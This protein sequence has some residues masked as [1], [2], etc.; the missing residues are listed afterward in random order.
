[1]KNAH[2][3]F[4]ACMFEDFLYVIGGTEVDHTVVSERFSFSKKMWQYISFHEKQGLFGCAVAVHNGC[5]Y[6]I[7]GAW[8]DGGSGREV[9]R[10]DPAKNVW[11]ELEGTKHSHTHACAFVV[12]GR[13]YVAGGKTDPPSKRY[14]GLVSSKFVEVYDEENDRWCDVPQ[15]HLPPINYGAVEV[16]NQIY[17][18]LGSFAYNSGIRIE[19]SEVYQVD[20]EEWEPI[21]HVDDDAVFI[22]MPV[23]RVEV[24]EEAEESIED[25]EHS[26]ELIL[27]NV[28]N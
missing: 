8:A 28:T 13:L 23:K 16:E 1:M 26:N 4:Q 19:E 17:F 2:R 3:N 11:T 27:E 14:R 25:Q 10:F 7:G 15:P 22:Y 5:I 21:S 24:A 9:C 18:I 12:N 6:S 20:L